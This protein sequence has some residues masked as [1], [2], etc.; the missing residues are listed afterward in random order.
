MAGMALTSGR[1]LRRGW[2]AALAY[3]GATV[4]MTW[5]LPRV[6]ARDVASDLGDSLYYMWAIGWGCT[7][8]GAILGGDL[9][10]IRTFFDA[11]IF[12][13][14]PLSLAYSD[15]MIAQAAQALPL[16]ALSA[17]AI[18]CYNLLFLSTFV[19]CGLGTYLFVRELTGN[20]RAA[21]VAGLLF[22]FAPYRLGHSAHLNLLSVQWTPLALY[23]LRRYFDTGRHLPL[24][25]AVTAL[26]VQNLSSLYYLLYFIPFVGAYALWEIATR[27]AWNAGRMWLELTTAA[28]ALGAAT[29]PFVVPY[30][31]LRERLSGLRDLTEVSRYS[32]DVYGYL[33]APSDLRIWG[34]TLRV[35]PKPEGELFPGFV[36]VALAVVGIIAWARRSVAGPTPTTDA[37]GGTSAEGASRREWLPRAL[38]VLSLAYVV[39]ATLVIYYRRLTIDIGPVTASAND[40]TRLLT[41][42][43]AALV[44][45]MALSRRARSVAA[46]MMRAPEA[47]ALVLLVASWW[48]SL[49][50]APTTLGRPL[51]ISAPYAFLFEHLPGFAGARVPA[52][53]AMI[54]AFALAILAGFGLHAIDRRR[55]GTPVLIAAAVAFLAEASVLPFPV[56]RVKPPVNL[57]P[58]E[59]RVYPFADAPRVY[60]AVR[61]LQRHA[62]L[63]EFPFGVAEYDRRAMYYSTTHWRPLINGYSGFYPPDY[64]RLRHFLSDLPGRPELARETQRQAGATHAL[65]HEAGYLRDEG[66]RV[67][68]WFHESGATE[69]FRDGSDALFALPAHFSLADRPVPFSALRSTAVEGLAVSPPGVV[70]S[71]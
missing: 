46:Q 47:W 60:T 14:Q 12:H 67:S 66:R 24:A 58:P 17:N 52:R 32:A 68:A 40:V 13:P 7:Q 25:G 30:L 4:L 10:R 69:I 59:A 41:F 51:E 49:G 6:L 34:D 23:G 15:H 33:T 55:W 31:S 2:V 50:P 64:A 38:V 36:P 11:N 62:V 63:I 1:A 65:V 3:V 35:Y 5:P 48:L 9:S 53:Y 70:T 19:L 20:A 71:R 57:A 8:F 26:V 27:R 43:A 21:F 44:I 22:A 42:A 29:A 18:L 56:N 45:A 16:Y 28:M 37:T 39:L 54:V 61:E